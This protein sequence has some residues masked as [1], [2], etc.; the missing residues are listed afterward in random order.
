MNGPDSASTTLHQDRCCNQAIRLTKPS[1]RVNE[2]YGDFSTVMNNGIG[3]RI[4]TRMR[5]NIRCGLS[6]FSVA[7]LAPA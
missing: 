6:S 1:Q 7:R 4:C 3:I 2:C 5:V